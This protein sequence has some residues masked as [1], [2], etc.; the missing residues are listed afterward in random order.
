MSHS[1]SDWEQ[2]FFELFKSSV[3]KYQKGHQKASGLVDA[4][5]QI[6]LKSIGYTEQEFF[7][8]VEDFS[9][10]G[11][12]TLET[13]VKIAGV[14]RDYFLQEQNGK[15]SSHLVSMSDLPAKDAEVE[16][17]V[18]LPRILP[19]AE[20]KLRGEM[21]PD[22]MFG[23]GGDRNF[24]A[25]HQIDPAEF[26]RKVWMAKGNHAEVIAWVKKTSRA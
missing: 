11:K 25:R 19:K 21:P 18:W 14:R 1:S 16:G 24:F 10:D 22:L 13:A 20:A 12:P 23:C 2:S 4:K 9:R 15:T 7:D 8:F 3:D 6:F 26:L 5:G 17:I